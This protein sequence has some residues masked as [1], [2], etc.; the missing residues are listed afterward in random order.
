MVNVVFEMV[1]LNCNLFTFDF[2]KNSTRR[3]F[4]L[5]LILKVCSVLV[6]RAY[7]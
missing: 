6:V 3:I 2:S 4:L 1:V 7:L 5:I